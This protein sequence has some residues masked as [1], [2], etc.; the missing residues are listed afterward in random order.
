MKLWSNLHRWASANAATLRRCIHMTVAGLLAYALAEIFALP[1]GYWAVFSAMFITQASVGGS[2]KLHRPNSKPW[3]RMTASSTEPTLS[4][5]RQ[6]P[7]RLGPAL[8]AALLVI[9]A[10]LAG[11]Y[12]FSRRTLV[13]TNQLAAPIWIA[14]GQASPVTGSGS[15]SSTGSA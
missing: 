14:V 3:R 11:W 13:F 6:R 8:L 4:R 12:L 2:V 5:R 1:Q 7:P 15:T 9:G 10:A